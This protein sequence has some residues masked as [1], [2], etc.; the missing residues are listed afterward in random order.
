MSSV[1][2]LP[3][4]FISL[5]SSNRVQLLAPAR[6]CTLYMS[7]HFW[8]LLPEQIHYV[9][10]FGIP[11]PIIGFSVTQALREKFEKKSVLIVDL[12]GMLV[13]AS[14]PFRPVEV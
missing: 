6:Q 10:L 5:L 14:A 8:E 7:T 9:P 13:F 12:I 11:A 1:G 3:L 4:W 2:S